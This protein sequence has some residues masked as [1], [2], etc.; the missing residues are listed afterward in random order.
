[1]AKNPVIK[2]GCKTA[3]AGKPIMKKSKGLKK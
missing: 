2:K 3:M 1:M